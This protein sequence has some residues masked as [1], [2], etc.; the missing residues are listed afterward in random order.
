[1]ACNEPFTHQARDSRN[2]MTEIPLS[3]SN[4]VGWVRRHQISD[5]QAELIFLAIAFRADDRGYYVCTIKEL[6]R[7]VGLG[8]L[9]VLA[10]YAGKGGYLFIL[11]TNPKF[12]D[13]QPLV[14]H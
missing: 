11:P 10:S 14:M 2:R 12:H 6:A 7:Q 5:R 1:M 9:E 13:C 4:S 8:V 3:L